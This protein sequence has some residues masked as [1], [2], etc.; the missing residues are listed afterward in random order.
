[1]FKKLDI[2]QKQDNF[3]YVFI[4]TKRDTLRYAIF[5]VNFEVGT[6]RYVTFSYSK[7]QT[8]RKKQDNLS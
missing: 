4:Y 5:Y 2:L 6:L 7:S 1:M 8:L 3:R